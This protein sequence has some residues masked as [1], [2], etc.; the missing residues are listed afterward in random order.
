[1]E[2]LLSKLLP[3]ALYPLGLA[4]LLQILGLL[5]RR[6]RWPSGCGSA[7]VALLWLA[8]MPL[9]SRQLVWGL[10]E[11]AS[12]LTPEPI[13]RADAV[14]VLGGGLRPAQAP[15]R[16]VE[17][18]E[19]GDRLLMG[20]DLLRRGRAPWLVVSGGRVAFTASAR[21]DDPARAS[22]GEK[23]GGAPSK[24]T[25][26][27]QRQ[28]NP[29]LPDQTPPSEAASATRLALW[30]GVPAARILRSDTPRNTAE[31]ATAIARLAQQ[32]GWHSLLLVTSATHLP[33]ALATFRRLT[34]LHIIPVACDYQLP[35]RRLY[36]RPTPAS[37]LL[38]LLPDADALATSTT[39]LKE[40][41]GL[42]IYRIRGWS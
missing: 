3:L 40:H 12:R 22:R 20:V 7:G 5:G 38:S 17:V 19:A 14:L 10:E 27:E 35:A 15:R 36:G 13:P 41:L 31:E 42:L 1:M 11:Q 23:P 24:A 16:S 39:S 18:G 26:S 2:F 28:P 6:R 32:R 34:P 8:A 33:R 37:L 4:L 29:M 30:L 21:A 25:L 9:V